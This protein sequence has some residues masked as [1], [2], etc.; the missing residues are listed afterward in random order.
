[1]L[2]VVEVA[3]LG[4]N[5]PPRLARILLLPFGDDVVVGFDFEQA[6][7]DQREALR[8]WLFQRQNLDVIIVEAQMPPV[9]FK[10]RF[11]EVVVEEGVVLEFCEFELSPARNS[12]SS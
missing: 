11:A 4:L 2:G 12:G 8:G 9:A 1:M 6:L 10:V 5:Q 7:E 3:A